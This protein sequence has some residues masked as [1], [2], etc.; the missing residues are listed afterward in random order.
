M[1]SP[2]PTVLIGAGQRGHHVYGRYALE[3]PD[4]LRFIGVVDP[5]P[6]RRERFAAA[7][8]LATNACFESVAA[9]ALEPPPA[10]AAIV[11]G[12]DLSH[13][14]AAVAVIEQGWPLLLEKPM[15]ATLEQCQALVERTRSHMVMVAHVLRYTPFFQTV[16]E[17]IVAGRLGEI[18]N[19]LHRENL[20]AWHMAHSFVRGNWART[21]EATPMIVQK[22]CHDFDILNWNLSAPVKH[23]ASFGSL[24]HFRPEQAPEGAT[25]RCADPCPVEGCPFDAR[26]IYLR[27]EWTGWP[28]HVMTDDLSPEGRMQAIQEGPYGR[29][30]Y[31]AGSDVVDHQTVLMELGDGATVTLEMTGHNPT[32]SRTMRYSGTVATLSAVLGQRSEIVITDHATGIEEVIAIPTSAGGHAGGDDAL[33]ASFINCVKSG[34]PP[35]TTPEVAWESHR[36]AFMAETARLNGSVIAV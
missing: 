1:A 16:H 22:C 9:L 35:A 2:L 29:C 27:P 7:H 11:A 3:H 6:K 33:I 23:L 34:E 14:D 26:Q 18:V 32:E 36:L 31:R 5:D 17:L 15:A 28:V 30:V 8:G 24:M 20:A 12:P 21:A 25:A 10:V 4:R 13:H 19:V